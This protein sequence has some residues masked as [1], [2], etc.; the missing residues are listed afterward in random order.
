MAAMTAQ[1]ELFS[2]N[3]EIEDLKKLVN[4]YEL[5]EAAESAWMRLA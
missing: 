1:T 2:K 3:K 4:K 5:R